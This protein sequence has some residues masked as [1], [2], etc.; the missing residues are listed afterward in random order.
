MVDLN[1]RHHQS[2]NLGVV[3]AAMEHAG[4]SEEVMQQV[5]M[6]TERTEISVKDAAAKY[7]IPSQ[8]IH[9]WIRRGHIRRL[10]SQKHGAGRP[11]VIIDETELIER[12]NRSYT[13]IRRKTY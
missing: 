4:A 8:T 12:I 10:A 3:V 5:V 7:G 13:R 6:A 9:A 11:Y 1:G 2:V